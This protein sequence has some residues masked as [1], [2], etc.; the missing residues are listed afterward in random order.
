MIAI[1]TLSTALDLGGK[2]MVSLPDECKQYIFRK[3]LT[4]D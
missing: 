4:V 2:L 3:S 1:A